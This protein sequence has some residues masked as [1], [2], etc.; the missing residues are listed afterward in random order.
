MRFMNRLVERIIGRILLSLAVFDLLIVRSAQNDS[1]DK[2]FNDTF[3]NESLNELLVLR[4]R[5]VRSAQYC[6]R[7]MEL[8]SN[9]VF[10]QHESSGGMI[11][12]CHL[13]S[14]FEFDSG[15]HLSQVI[16]TP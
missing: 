1:L 15:Y 8:L 4:L 13:D 11:D 6:A 2:S 7:A 14:I 12:L 10:S 16:E 5:R 3:R 9:V